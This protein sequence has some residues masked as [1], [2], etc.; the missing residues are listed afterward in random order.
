MRCPKY[1]LNVGNGVNLEDFR[2]VYR[3][4]LVLLVLVLLLLFLLPLSP[5][6]SCT[7]VCQQWLGSTRTNVLFIESYGAVGFFFGFRS[8]ILMSPGQSRCE[9]QTVSY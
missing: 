7:L 9:S 6:V 8:K 2:N 3:P 1:Q 4:L 5:S